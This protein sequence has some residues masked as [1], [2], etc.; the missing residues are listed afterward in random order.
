MFLRKAVASG[1]SNLARLGELGGKLL[2]YFPINRE[3]SEG[4]KESTLL[5]SEDHLKLVREIVSV[6]KIQAEA[7]P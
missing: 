7:L 2:P 4:E 6:K 3:R 5:V 1:G